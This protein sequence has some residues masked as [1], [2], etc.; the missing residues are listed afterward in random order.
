MSNQHS[1]T[2]E[3]I[4]TMLHS[5]VIICPT[6]DF[7]YWFHGGL[8]YPIKGVF[9]IPVFWGPKYVK[10]DNFVCLSIN[11]LVS[12]YLSLSGT[13]STC[14]HWNVFQQ[15]CYSNTHCTHRII[16]PGVLFPGCTWS[17][18]FQVAHDLSLC[19]IWSVHLCCFA[20]LLYSRSTGALEKI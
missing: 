2:E 17:V 15:M 11:F 5:Y 8:L 20:L 3:E 12:I 1:Y 7:H 14:D 6:F 9:C 19:D 4:C 16:P 18:C 10:T 13:L